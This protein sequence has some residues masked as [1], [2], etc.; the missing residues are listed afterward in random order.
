VEVGAEAVGGWAG[1][2]GDEEVLL[3]V[4]PAVHSRAVKNVAA[5][6]RRKV[7]HGIEISFEGG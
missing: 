1:A 2:V 6:T 3:L 7:R 5:G 4:Q